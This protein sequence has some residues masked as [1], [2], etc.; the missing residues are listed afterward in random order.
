MILEG[1]VTTVAAEGRMHLTPMGPSVEDTFS[2]LLLRP[3]PSSTTYQNLLRH[4]EG[5]FHITDDAALMAR[6]AVGLL[7]EPPAARPAETVQG[8]VLQDCCRA[9]EFRVQQID[10]SQERVHIHAEVVQT[11]MVR[12][13]VGFHR[14]R[15][16]LLEAAILATRF[17]WLPTVE[18][19][20]E[21]KKLRTI[22]T[23]T[24]GE[25]EA[26]V[27]TE[28]EDLWRNYQAQAVPPCRV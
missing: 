9:Y 2:T 11:H 6:A 14:G 17:A 20:Q 27:M 26:A 8:F 16:A 28:L 21:F 15:H 7:S 10:A 25:K 3:F 13:F 5:V 19:E 18:I 23:K 4:G 22:I 12:E 24:G 1:L